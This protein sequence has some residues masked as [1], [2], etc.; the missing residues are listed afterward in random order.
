[1]PT[2]SCAF[3]SGVRPRGDRIDRSGHWLDRRSERIDRGVEL[4][5]ET[6]KRF[7]CRLALSVLARGDEPRFCVGD[8]LIDC[9]DPIGERIAIDGSR[10]H[11]PV[12]ADCFLD[13]VGN[14]VRA[15]SLDCSFMLALCLG[16]LAGE[17]LLLPRSY[18]AR[19]DS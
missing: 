17:R 16:K 15:H 19:N 1:M 18:S 9:S 12:A 6:G 14:H 5:G 11:R 7:R 13:P 4:V 10:H 2:P 3:A 8:L